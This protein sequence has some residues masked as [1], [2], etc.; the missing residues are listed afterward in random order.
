MS[1]LST[2]LM[3]FSSSDRMLLIVLLVSI[4]ASTIYLFKVHQAVTQLPRIDESATVK[5]S[6]TYEYLF[7]K[8]SVIIPVYNEEENIQD[9][10]ES[11]LIGTRLP[12]ELFEVWVID[13]RST[14]RTLEILQALQLRCFDSRLKILSGLPCPK[15]Q[16]WTGKNWA[17][18]QGAECSDGE[19]LL[20][21]DADVRLK[22]NAV[23][24][25]VQIAIHRKLDLLT[26]ISTIV[27][28]SL[29]E[30]LV[31]PLMFINVLVSFN[32]RVVK[33]PQTKTAYA[34]GPFLLFR[35]STYQKIGGH[36]AVA[37]YIAED[38]AFARKIKQEGF[39]IQPILGPELASLRMYRDWCSLWEGWTKVL[40]AGTQRNVLVMLFLVVAMVEIYSIPWFGLL[41]AVYQL[42]NDSPQHLIG[43]ILAGLAILLQ[44]RIRRYGSQALGTST[45]YWWLQGVGGLLITVITI[46]SIVKTETGWGWTWRGRKLIAVK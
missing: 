38:V 11:V 28:G 29:I 20:F 44:Y 37:D 5:G 45:K 1:E 13:D 35:A 26:C 34:L 33:D 14:D 3:S 31:Q 17:C 23:I 39:R 24:K 2:S 42:L 40:Y 15:Q 18:H 43:L 7:S 4:L 21:L 25:T 10:V 6:A 22:P 19:F 41:I 36:K 32:S 9:C 12:P 27:C 30:W 46:A 16:V 8:V